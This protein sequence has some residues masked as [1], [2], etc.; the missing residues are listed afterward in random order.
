MQCNKCR[1][2][3]EKRKTRGANDTENVIRKLLTVDGKCPLCGARLTF[4]AKSLPYHARMNLLIN[5]QIFLHK[6]QKICENHLLGSNLAPEIN[7]PHG[8]EI[9]AD[10]SY[11]LLQDLVALLKETTSKPYLDFD[12][13]ELSDDDY[14]T[15]TGWTRAQFQEMECHLSNLRPSN[16]RSV[17]SALAMFWIKLKTSLSFQQ[18]AV[19]FNL[20][21][22]HGR[23]YVANTVHAVAEEL[24]KTFV[25]SNLGTSA[26][27][28]ETAIGH[29][30]V[31]SSTLFGKDKVITIWDGTYYYIQKAEDHE[32]SRRTYSGHKNR[33]L[34]KFMS[35]VLPDGYVLD[36]LGPYMS[37]GKNNDAG[38][39]RH[40]MKTQQELMDWMEEEDVAILDRS[41]RDVIEALEEEGLE[42][43]M[44]SYLMKGVPQHSVE[45]ANDSRLIT[46]VR[47]I[48]ESYHGRIKKWTF[49]YNRISNRPHSV[50]S[51]ICENYHGSPQCFQ[52]ST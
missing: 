49:F 30:T 20:D 46:K 12:G 50:P 5:S 13:M 27:T 7:I 3:L 51:C 38:M 40:I 11:E 43:K 26:T 42:C 36:V 14:K 23:L 41:F 18:I 21:R 29:G 24:D 35:V 44:P 2:F 47:W 39:T 9:H 33:P 22:E 1:M 48:V 28:R 25:P 4:H 52:T 45:D 19:L 10:E 16:V 8:S 37:D 34:V 6:D 17:R 31:F 15:W 32:L